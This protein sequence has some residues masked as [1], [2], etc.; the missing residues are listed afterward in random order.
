MFTVV[1]NNII[2]VY[3]LKQLLKDEIETDCQLFT[4]YIEY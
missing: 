1:Y 4:G 3:L 2:A